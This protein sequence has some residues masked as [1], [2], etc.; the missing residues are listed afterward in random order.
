MFREMNV[1]KQL[2]FLGFS[3]YKKWVKYSLLYITSLHIFICLSELV[4]MYNSFTD[5]P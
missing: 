4:Q 3:V 2:A 1:K 5:L